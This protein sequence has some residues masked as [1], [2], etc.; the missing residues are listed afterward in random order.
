MDLGDSV[1]RDLGY[2]MA[3]TLL[4]LQGGRAHDAMIHIIRGPTCTWCGVN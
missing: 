3:E 1:F 4:V 2:Y